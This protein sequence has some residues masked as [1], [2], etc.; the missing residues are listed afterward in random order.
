MKFSKG[1]VR[2]S[3]EKCREG[4]LYWKILGSVNEEVSVICGY[5]TD[6]WNRM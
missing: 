1:P 2:P 4:N 3:K 6:G 5:E